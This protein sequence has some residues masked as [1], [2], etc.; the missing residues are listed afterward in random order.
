VRVFIFF[1]LLV[2]CASPALAAQDLKKLRT[3][4]KHWVFEATSNALTFSHD[5]Y[6]ERLSANA[7][8]FTPKG[9]R[10][11]M[12]TMLDY[13]I[14][15]GVMKRK[16]TLVTNSF[17][18][19]H[20]RLDPY[21]QITIDEE[22]EDERYGLYTWKVTVPLILTF[23]RGAFAQ[24]YRFPADVRVV[25]LTAADGSFKIDTWYVSSVTGGMTPKN[26][27]ADRP[28]KDYL[29]CYRLYDSEE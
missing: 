7:K 28:K 8:Y 12:R 29:Y 16:E 4:M 14:A 3:A 2:F 6:L 21:D 19:K 24:N 17:W 10:S 15:D 20:V 9:C 26:F 1:L 11:Y 27:R 13:G 5:T 25:Q 23:S 22:E 18:K